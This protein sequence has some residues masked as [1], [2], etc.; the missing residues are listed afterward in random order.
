MGMPLGWHRR[1][2]LSIAGQLPENTED[3]LLVLQCV[4]ELVDTY[5]CKSDEPAPARAANVIPFGT[6][7]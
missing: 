2:A 3:A 4:K 6:A 7:S 5:L 1:H